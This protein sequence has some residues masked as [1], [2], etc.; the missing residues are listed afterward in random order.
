M[1][2]RYAQVLRSRMKEGRMFIQ[3]VAG[4]RQVGKT[5]IV[6]QVL[7]SLD[8]PHI[9]AAADTQQGNHD[10]IARQWDRARLLARA[11]NPVVL[12][13]DELQKIQGWSEVVKKLWD[14]DGYQKRDIRVIVSGSSRLL[15]EKGLSESLQGRFELMHVPHWSYGEMREVFGLSLDAFVYFGGYPGSMLLCHDEDRWRRY[16]VSSIIDASIASDILGL[17]EV[18][19][20]ALLRQLFLLGAQ[21]SAQKLSYTK[22][23]GQLQDAG[24][25]TT[26]ARYMQ[27]LDESCLLA[28]LQKYSGSKVRSRVSSP[29]LQVFDNALFSALDAL[30]FDE[31]R[32]NPEVWG[33]YVESAVGCH[34][35]ASSIPGHH[36]VEYW[37]DG[38]NEIDFIFHHNDQA[39]G[40]EVKSG[41]QVA[42]KSM[43]AFRKAYPDMPV[44]VVG[45]IEGIP[46]EEFLLMDPYQLFR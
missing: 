15:L 39:C 36:E 8:V 30:T 37:R 23:L 32:T 19:K 3:V 9:Y 44:Y 12:A 38:D 18:R 7:D 27:L 31:A 42:G 16:I 26:L 24:N 33:R 25:T 41:S 34:L 29:K 11:G 46:L 5:T 40:I 10:W 2:R 4:P 22:M 43:Q 45:G 1:E 20:P 35:L 6:H 28:G 21:Y 14:E 13:F 17:E